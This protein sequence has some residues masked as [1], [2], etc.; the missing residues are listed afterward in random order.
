[1]KRIM[2]YK[3]YREVAA[4]P[5]FPE[6]EKEILDYWEKN[7]IFN[8]SITKNDSCP[9]FIFYDGPPFANGMP[10]YGHLLTGFIKDSVARFQT[11]IGKRV[12][13]RFGWDCHGLPAE[14]GAEKELNISGKK[15]IKDFGIDKFNQH[16][17]ESVMK[18]A[19]KWYEYVKR[20]ARWVDFV[21]DY[22]TMN[23]DFMES[24][25][26]GFKELYKKNLIYKSV[27]VMPYS[28][29]CETPLSNFETRMDNAYRQKASKAITVVFKSAK[30]PSIFINAD[31]DA[32]YFVAWT[33]TPWT[34][35][36]NLA[37]A[38]NKDIVYTAIS[39]NKNFYVCALSQAER[40]SKIIEKNF[41]N[42]SCTDY[43][44]TGAELIGVTYSPLFSYFK[45]TINAFKILNGDFVTDEEGTGIV[46][47]APGFGE[48]DFAICSEH[49][50]PIICPVDDSGKF[51]SE[52]IDYEGKHVFDTNDDI[53]IFLK[54]QGFW[55]QTEQYLHQYPHCWRTD[56]PLIYKALPSWYV[57]VT[58]IKDKMI[59]L[60]SKINWVPEH[61]RDGQFG[62]WLENA[63][64]WSISRQRF[65][66]TPIPVWESDNPEY[67]RV[68]VYGSI[69]EIEKDFN[70]KV[71]DL[72]RPFIDQIT[73]KNPDDKT[74]RSTMKRVEDVFDCWFES[75]SMPYAQS[76]YPFKNREW[77]QNNF[78]A[79][80]IVEYIAQTRGWFYTLMVLS[81]ALFD[82]YPFK[83]CICHGVVLDNSGQ[84]LSKRLNNYTDPMEV[85]EK[86]GADA[87]RLLMLS[88]SIMQGGNLLLD[89]N[90]EMVQDTLR[91]KIKPIWNAYYFFV[92]YANADKITPS[93]D[94]NPN[95]NDNDCDKMDIYIFSKCK[96]S[97]KKI[98]EEMLQYNTI[99]ACKEIEKFFDVLNNWYIRRNKKRFWDHTYT[100]NKQFAYNTLFS[101]LCVMCRAIAP[102]LPLISEFV[103]KNL[104]GE[105]VHL[106]D[107]PDYNEILKNIDQDFDN[108][109][110]AEM[111]EVRHICATALAVRNEHNIRIRQP[112]KTIT[113]FIEEGQKD[114]NLI[115]DYMQNIIKDE[116]NVKNFIISSELNKY[117]KHKLQLIFSEIGK[118]VPEKM[119]DIVADNKNNNWTEKEDGLYIGGTVLSKEQYNIVLEPLEKNA[120]ALPHNKSMIMLDTDIDNDLFV[121]GI[122]R[123][124]VRLIQE[125][126]KQMGFGITDR[127]TTNIYTTDL[128][129][130]E[131][132]KKWEDYIKSQ[133]LSNVFL[134]KQQQ[135]DELCLKYRVLD[136]NLGVLLEKNV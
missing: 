96:E 86:Y 64:D 40:I 1:M 21:N 110:V 98:K 130:I 37:L 51:T 39:C 57:K 91:L 75:G 35:P 99:N 20:Q 119:K 43:K 127:I 65:W 72:H 17:R 15:A 71:Q 7:D 28:W 36:S 38:I 105:S 52:I 121:E 94:L 62:K 31:C 81:T 66:G 113:Y 104:T 90:C 69:A 114:K 78:P 25:M 79:D 34:L 123:D 2:E 48:D 26:W 13:R 10:H 95:C 23:L 112:L 68:D 111:D 107:F 83:N 101:V 56:T 131:A 5:N 16:C 44:F 120:Y 134:L 19:D 109:L 77:F 3:P 88:S 18:F 132:C 133:T 93:F 118:H 103:Y 135:D 92:V 55:L 45:D 80:F 32:C 11:M 106:S 128:K 33:T 82:T 4:S 126:R 67:P 47:C 136:S 125:S 53:I 59:E 76:H 129:I 117:A 74:G 14:M 73:R 29:A 49:K 116:I 63:R 6:L 27:R 124:L 61:I 24:V 102:L 42:A 108:K 70:V 84:K 122:A 30:V 54:K 9:D 100:Q 58:D 46:H 85:M 97:V 41:G 12:Q 50:I 8:K 22:K 89:K 115:D 87:L 60:N